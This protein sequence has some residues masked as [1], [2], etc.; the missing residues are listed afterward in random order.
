MLYLL[1]FHYN[2]GCT[3][4]IVTFICT[5]LV[6]FDIAFNMYMNTYKYICICA[7]LIVMICVCYN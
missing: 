7:L 3:N 6:L 4:A 5:L 2:N 1:L